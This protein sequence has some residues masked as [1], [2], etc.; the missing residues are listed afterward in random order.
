MVTWRTSVAARSLIKL[1]ARHANRLS[2][3]NG[4]GLGCISIHSC[5]VKQLTQREETQGSA[6][7]EHPLKVVRDTL[8]SNFEA[9]PLRIPVPSRGTFYANCIFC[10]RISG[11]ALRMSASVCATFLDRRKLIKSAAALLCVSSL[12]AMSAAQQPGG[13]SKVGRDKI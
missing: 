12:P 4:N 3:T 7:V 8:T 9:L 10:N 6:G 13:N 1:I 5:S 2:L 11:K